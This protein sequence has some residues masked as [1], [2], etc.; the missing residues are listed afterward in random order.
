MTAKTIKEYEK[1]LCENGIRIMKDAGSDVPV[2]S[3]TYNS[4]EAIAGTMFVC[5]GAHFKE[6]YLE[7]AVSRGA[8]CYISEKAYSNVPGCDSIIV[9]DIRA[10][11][12]VIAECFYG[13]LYEKLHMTGITGTKGKSTTA[14]FLRQ[15]LDD[16]MD[17]SGGKKSAICSGIDN[18]DGVINE[19]SHLTTPEIMELYKHMSNAVQS[20]IEYMTMEVSSQALKYGR[21]EGIDYE[22]ACFLNIGSDHIS[23]I[24]HPDFEDYFGSKLLIFKQCRKACVNLDCEGQE[25]LKEA[26]SVAPE[27]IT[28]SQKD[29]AANVFAKDIIS[30]EGRVSFTAAVQGINGYADTEFEIKLASFGKINVENAIASVALAVALGIPSEFIVSGLSKAVAPG[31]MEVFRSDDGKKIVLVDYAHNK[32]SFEALFENIS[33]EFPSRD[34]S[35]VFGA[36]GGK[37]LSRREELGSLAGKHCA[38][39]YLTE[40]DPGEEDNLKIC[41]ELA[42][43]VKASGGTFEVIPDR[44]DAIRKAINDAGENRIVIVAGKGRETRIKRGTVYVDA[45]SDVELVKAALSGN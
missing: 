42:G 20:G 39:S 7:E 37:A 25:K 5:K 28:F 21:V 34:I 31:R 3:I 35:I 23:P 1:A 19:E 18:Y 26:V 45:P 15:I 29:P 43:F 6:S 41:N 27:I 2:T 11:M 4:K 8:V 14:Y 44:G 38:V 36:P 40:E 10:A 13:K 22:V 24:E 12:P 30:N 9:D 33:N 16:Y 17:A 32:L